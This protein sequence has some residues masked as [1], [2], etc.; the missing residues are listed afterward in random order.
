MFVTVGSSTLEYCGT[1]LSLAFS[2]DIKVSL[3]LTEALYFYYSSVL[4]L[5][6]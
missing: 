1:R 6:E 2:K 5:N 3:E 4:F